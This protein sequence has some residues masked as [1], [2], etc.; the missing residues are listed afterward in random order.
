MKFYYLLIFNFFEYVFQTIHT[1]L[2][3]PKYDFFHSIVHEGIRHI[4]F[5]NE[6]QEKC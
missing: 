1:C 4:A 3:K 5:K 6:F 2:D